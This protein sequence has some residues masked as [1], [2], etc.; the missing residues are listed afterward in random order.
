MWSPETVPVNVIASSAWIAPISIRSP[1][2][3]IVTVPFDTHSDSSIWI[4]L[5]KPP[6]SG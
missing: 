2:S 3:P 5:E 1:S 4:V 6:P